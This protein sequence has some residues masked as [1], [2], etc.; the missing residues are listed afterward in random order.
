MHPILFTFGNFTIHTYGFSVA[1]AFATAIFY[2]SYSIKKSKEKIISQDDLYSLVMYIMVFS[3][4]G[5]RL[6]F[7]FTDLNEFILYP[8]GIFKIWQ[9]GLVYYGGFIASIIF[10]I[11]YAKRKKIHLLKLGDFFAPALALGHALGRIG[12]FFAGCCYG[13]ESSLPWAVAFIN[14]HSLAVRGKPLHPT[15]LYEAFANLLL[16]VFLYFYSKKGHKSGVSFAVYIT[17]YAVLRFI[18]EFFRGDY[19]GVRYF[20]F[21]V[22][23]IISVFLFTAGVFIICRKK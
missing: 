22:S 2:L 17:G 18:I 16:F 3:V 5:A 15:Q 9:G 4:A 8:L 13:K 12:C 6:F 19:R 23:Q 14:E 21:S 10:A 11:T 1:T 7:V 20:D